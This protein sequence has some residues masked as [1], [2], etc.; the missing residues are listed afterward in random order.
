MR[1]R[2]SPV[3]SIAFGTS[4]KEAGEDLTGCPVELAAKQECGTQVLM[5]YEELIRDAMN[6]NQT[7]FARQDYV[8]Q[9]WRILEPVLN[10]PPPVQV[11]EPGSWG[12]DSAAKLTAEL[13]GWSDPKPDPK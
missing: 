13:G 11:Y 8:E 2:L 5:P 10:N 3:P 7:W 4:I 6:G 9:A 1:F 12:P